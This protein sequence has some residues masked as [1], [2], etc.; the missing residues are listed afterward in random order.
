MA[1]G[2]GASPTNWRGTGS[3]PA[4]AFSNIMVF[5]RSPSLSSH[6]LGL[7]LHY[8]T[9]ELVSL[10]CPD[11]CPPAY[12][13]HDHSLLPPILEP[14]CCGPQFLLVLQDIAD[15]LQESCQHNP[16]VCCLL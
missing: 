2:N 12:Q 7:G 4:R 10:L 5:F 1:K 15:I 8:H 3:C 13:C 14:I 9:P 6:K 16:N 11:T